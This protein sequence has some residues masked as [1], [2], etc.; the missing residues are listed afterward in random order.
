VVHVLF[1]IAKQFFGLVVV[2]LL[3]AS[4]AATFVEQ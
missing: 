3:I 1:G 2:V 4:L